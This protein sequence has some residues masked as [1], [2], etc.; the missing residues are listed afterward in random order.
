MA[1][2]GRLGNQVVE[3]TGDLDEV[4]AKR[5]NVISI[6]IRIKGVLSQ[7]VNEDQ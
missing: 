7:Y 1:T 5:D 6:E 4:E 2:R 3:S